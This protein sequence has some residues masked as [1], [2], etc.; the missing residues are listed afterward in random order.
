MPAMLWR[1]LVFAGMELG[2][3]RFYGISICTWPG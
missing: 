2:V 3:P 1:C